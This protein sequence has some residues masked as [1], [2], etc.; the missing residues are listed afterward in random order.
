MKKCL[1]AALSI[2]VLGCAGLS[3]LPEGDRALIPRNTKTQI[4]LDAVYYNSR[5]KESKDPFGAVPAGETLRF[6]LSTAAGDIDEAALVLYTV[7]QELIS[8]NSSFYEWKEVP[9]I[10]LASGD[11][12]DPR[13]IWTLEIVLEEPALL[14]YEF[15]LSKGNDTIYLGNNNNRFQGPEFSVFGTGGL[16]SFR[17]PDL[18]FIKPKPYTLT[19]YDHEALV[20]PDYSREMI[21]YYIF[22]E[23]FKNGNP[24]NDPQVGPG[25][26]EGEYS[27]EVH[28]DWAQP[29]P[30]KP[31]SNQ[32]GTKEDDELWNNDFY[33]GDL[34][35]IIEKLDHIQSLGVNT[36]YLNPIF[37]ARSNH[38][39]DTSDYRQVDPHFGGNEA[40]ALLIAE[41]KS[42]GMGVILDASLNH[43]GMDSP[44]FDRFGKFDSL[45]AF[46]AEEIRE[47]SP[48]YDWFEFK[49][50][51]KTPDDQYN[52]WAVPTLANLAES[53]SWKD[54]AYRDPDSVTKYWL[55]Q[56]ILGWRMDVTPYVTDD[57]WREWRSELKATYP[58]AITFAEVW[59][60]ASRYFLGDTFDSTMNY[61]FRGMAIELANGDPAEKIREGLYRILENYPEPVLS[62][63]MNFFS[64]HDVT[65]GLYEL[66]Y[67]RYGANNYD[68]PGRRSY[69]PWLFSIPFPEHRPSIMGMRL[70]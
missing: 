42:R 6:K 16:G 2:S 65:R 22:P 53:D 21:M 41:T 50:E 29:L 51:G 27:V 11:E 69:W 3:K 48:Y 9:M 23:R 52:Y 15:R 58:E 31:N 55:E 39:Y 32:D 24:E 47:D 56:G 38:K 46:E 13:D 4:N 33:G 61:A 49:P 10:L 64:S 28:E 66:G 37:F 59:Y 40:F 14:G 1:L 60:E 57:F 18:E 70:V 54:Y 7:E 19:V 67:R 43:L 25:T 17:D 30:Y 63:L 20:L 44:Y 8:G 5:D 36:L 26:F 62:R 68:R 34:E 45:G 12:E 35:G